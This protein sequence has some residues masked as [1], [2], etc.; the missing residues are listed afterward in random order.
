MCGCGGD[1]KQDG[2]GKS[3]HRSSPYRIMPEVD[4]SI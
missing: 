3:R 1:G 4:C 2:G